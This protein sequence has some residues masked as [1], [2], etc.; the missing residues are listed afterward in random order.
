MQEQD[1]QIELSATLSSRYFR[2]IAAGLVALGGLYVGWA[3]P[4][5]PDLGLSGH[6]ALMGLI[7][8]LGLW[9]FKPL[10]IPFSVTAGL[11]LALF[12]ASGIPAVN[13]FSGY[14]SPA[15]WILIPAL[16]FGFALAHTGLGRRLA[17]L[18]L[19]MFE[20]TYLGLTL[21]WVII[22]VVL[23][24]LTPSITVRTAIMMPVAVTCCDLAKLPNGSKGRGLVL[25][26]AMS[27]AMLPG[28]G[29]MTGTLTGPTLIGFYN[30]TDGLQG[31][32]N[33]GSWAQ[34]ALLEVAV[35][36]V[37]LAV[38]GYVLM[39]P[40]EPMSQF[41]TKQVFIEVYRKLGA[42][43]RQEKW[44]AGILVMAFLM[45]VTA[46]LHQ[47]PDAATC[48][49][50]FFLLTAGGVISTQDIG[51]GINWDIV[52]FF[53]AGLC[54]GSVLTFTGVSKWLASLVIP[55]LA[56]VAGNPWVFCFAIMIFLFVW[57]FV[58]IVIMIPTEAILVSIL[59]A[60][61]TAYHINPL[62]WIGLFVLPVNAMFMNYQNSFVLVGESLA[63]EKG[64]QPNQLLM[65]GSIYFVVSLLALLVVI[66][67]WI[68][69]GFFR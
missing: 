31:L 58:D 61:A 24:A 68:G 48:L 1:T 57:R 14:T 60:I 25:L 29:W 10:E 6:K 11:M 16:F 35:A 36:T 46:P 56:P 67:Y 39:K 37:L 28:A 45:F 59:P 66:P 3:T 65:Y 8:A 19:R 7:I 32:I 64:W 47:I 41:I 52:I 40:S 13:V 53:G 38:G 5:A 62:V 23:S 51:P 30:A 69:Q 34:V 33:F 49:F 63:K 54:I 50:A 43:S 9:I 42:W 26:T 12:L 55:A 15:V 21:A 22:G 27:M 18:V 17:F 20:P 44:T 2:V 4:F